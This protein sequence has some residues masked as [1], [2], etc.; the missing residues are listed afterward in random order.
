MVIPLNSRNDFRI[1]FKDR[2]GNEYEE[3]LKNSDLVFYNEFYERLRIKE[4]T[5][6]KK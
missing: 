1:I 3:M 2:E 4:Y 6:F 5:Y